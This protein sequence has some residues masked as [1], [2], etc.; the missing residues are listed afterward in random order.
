MTNESCSDRPRMCVSG[1]TSS[2]PRSSTSSMTSGGDER[3]E[4]VEDRLR[5]G[6]HLLVLGAGQV[7]ELLAAHRVQRPEHDDLACAAA[8]PAP[9]PGR[10][11]ARAPTCRCRRGRRARRCRPP[12]RAAGRARSR[13]SADRPC[14][15]N[16]SRSPR[17]SRTCLSAVTRP[18]A[19]PRRECSRRPVWHGRSARPTS[20]L[21]R[22]R[23]RRARRRRPR[24]TSSSAMPGPA[25]L[26]GQLGPV[27]VR[28]QPDRRGLDPHRQV[29]GDQGDVPALGGEVAARR[30][31]CGSRC[32]RAGSR[33]AA[34][35]RSVWFSSTRRVPPSSPI[36]TGSSSRPCLTRRSSSMPQR[37]PGEPAEL[38]VVPLALQLADHDQRQHHLV[39][40]EPRRGPR[41]RTAARWCRGR[42]SCG[43]RSCGGRPQACP[44]CGHHQRPISKVRHAHEGAGAGP[45]AVDRSTRQ[46]LPG[47]VPARSATDPNGTTPRLPVP[48][49]RRGE[50]RPTSDLDPTAIA[51]TSFGNNK[52]HW[53]EHPWVKK[54][55]NDPDSVVLQAL[56]GFGRAHA[57]L[58][59]RSRTAASSSAATRPGAGKVGLVS[60][61]GSGHEPLHGGFVGLGMLDAA[62][63]G[64]VFTSPTPD[65]IVAATQAVNGGRR[66][67]PHRQEL[68]RRRDELPD[69]RRARRATRASRSRPSLVDDDV[70]VRGLACTRPGG[71]APA[72]P[73]WSRRSPAR[74]AEAGRRA[75][76]CRRARAAGERAAAAASA[77]R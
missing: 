26:D 46:G 49:H 33:P 19:E 60:G 30:R 65:Q 3:A 56:R 21:E 9:P 25:G 35:D 76:R 58:R 77:W 70:A 12:G 1:S 50:P 2:M 42:R 43:I 17:T 8:A 51:L 5:P 61:G 71:A 67:R 38:G 16:A 73:S 4:R 29:L 22:A 44:P 34:T 6:R 59:G 36:G 11:T 40:A 63:P 10:R 37:L 41:D 64:E 75:G 54:L 18:S 48:G 66:R 24:A 47:S 7:A 23:R 28:V 72:P 45:L 32:R 20:Q 13:C 62:C 15:P 69:R 53:G 52:D 14:S 68:H 57:D 74:C 39:L 31:G 55:I 27:L